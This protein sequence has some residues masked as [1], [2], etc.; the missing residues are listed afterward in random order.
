M[1]NFSERKHKLIEEF[2]LKIKEIIE[3]NKI[4]NLEDFDLGLYITNVFEPLFTKYFGN[5]S[6]QDRVIARSSILTTLKLPE[7]IEEYF[8]YI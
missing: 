6:E 8:N 5:E 7:K 1:D 3:L 2:D 4:D